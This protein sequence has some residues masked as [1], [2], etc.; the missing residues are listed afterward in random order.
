M[1]GPPAGPNI[2]L[3]TT[4]RRDKWSNKDEA[5]VAFK[6]NPLFRTWDPR[7]VDKYVEFGLRE[8]PTALY[9]SPSPSSQDTK[10]TTKNMTEGS[11]EGERDATEKGVTLT[12]TKHQEAWSFTRS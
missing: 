9:P 1:R 5:A 4:F 8:L 7:V 2:A 6:K 10:H 12:T 3:P 11:S